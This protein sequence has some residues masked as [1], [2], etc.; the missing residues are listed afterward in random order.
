MRRNV[1]NALAAVAALAVT[2]A[3]M[4]WWGAPDCRLSAHAVA[5]RHGPATGELAEL[6]S[7]EGAEALARSGRAEQHRYLL[8]DGLDCR[9][10]T[11]YRYKGELF[12]VETRSREYFDPIADLPAGAVRRIRYGS[13]GGGG[14]VISKAGELDELLGAIRRQSYRM[15]V[16]YGI[17]P[18]VRDDGV[19]ASV[20]VV[21]TRMAGTHGCTLGLYVDTGA[22]SETFLSGHASTAQFDRRGDLFLNYAIY[23]QLKKLAAARGFRLAD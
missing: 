16:D 20:G 9:R 5:N 18:Y 7:S 8:G 23:A 6:L 12:M 1:V 3:S 19:G 13:R 4:H 2:V 11:E 21:S 10:L 15:T 14:L 17:R 22:G